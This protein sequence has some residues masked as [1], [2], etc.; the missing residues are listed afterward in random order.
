MNPI[1]KFSLIAAFLL[2]LKPEPKLS[3]RDWSE[4]NRILDNKS[5]AEPGRYNASR[6]P[7][8]IEIMDNLSLHSPVRKIIVMKGIQL[9]LTEVGNNWIGYIIDQAPSPMMAIQP[10]LDM[11]KRNVKLRLDPMFDTIPRIAEKMGRKR[12]REGGNTMFQKDYPG[13]SLVLTGANSA[14][15]LSSMPV[16]FLFL[17]E[18]DRYPMDVDGEGSPISLAEKRTATFGYKK[19]IFEISTPT[20]EGRSVIENDF[21][22]TD[23][24]YFFVPCPHCNEK[25][26]LV[27]KNL[28]WEKGKYDSCHYVC[29]HCK[30][31]IEQRHKTW[32]LHNGEWIATKPEN[33]SPDMVGYHISTLYS[34]DGWMSWAEIAKEWEECQGDEPKMKAFI[35]T[36]LGETYK[37]KTEAP[38]WEAL[39]EKSQLYGL[40]EN[41]PLGSVAFLTAGVDVQGDRLEVEIV[42]WMRGRNSQQID[43]RVLLGD[44]NEKDVWDQLTKVLDEPFETED[45]RTLHIRYMAVDTGYRPDKVNDWAK[46]HGPTRVL[47]VRGDEKVQAPFMPPRV[48][49]LNKQGKKL[50][51]MKVWHVGVSYLKGQLYGWLRLNVNLETGEVPAGYCLFTKR[52]PH[53]F[54]GLTAEAIQPVRNNRGMITYQWVKKYER[55]E[56]L[57]VRVY[58][59]AAAYVLGFDRWTPEKWEKEIQKP[60]ATKVKNVVAAPKEIK[61][62]KKKKRAP[63]SSGYWDK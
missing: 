49:D 40:P 62:V 2:A 59:T 31:K 55:N 20:I 21:L 5:S 24:R 38:E 15:S 63:K 61:E 39:Y 36:I 1:K 8:N 10:T 7:F 30:G 45:K 22:K 29:E 52:D 53:Y 28:K 42:G 26:I 17:D 19:K 57:D 23:Q 13:G 37:E 44:T 6:T 4:K 48:V 25:Q 9:G 58:A 56:P 11:M 3:L 51:K 34:P 54:R 35:N 43:Y 16:R 46:L 50:G 12:S 41:K 18:V 14:A 33:S 60:V 47:P 32:M 27:F